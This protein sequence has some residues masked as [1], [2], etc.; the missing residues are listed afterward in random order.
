MVHD[1]GI[2]SLR[3]LQKRLLDNLVSSLP[4]NVFINSLYPQPPK[5]ILDVANNIKF[6]DL[7]LV[8][9]F[10]NVDRVNTNGSMYFPE[11]GP[12]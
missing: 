7:I 12:V 5:E 8:A 4:I 6:R 1:H 3:T 9:I 10:L 2:F 11:G